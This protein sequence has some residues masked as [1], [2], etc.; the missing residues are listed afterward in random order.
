[1]AAYKNSHFTDLAPKAKRYEEPDNDVPGLR[2][3]VH[4]SGAKSWVL[5]YWFGSKKY[6]L[7]IGGFPGVDVAA[8]R[9]VAEEA[10]AKVKLGRNPAQEKI[11]ARQTADSEAA[12]AFD[13]VFALYERKH[14]NRK[15]K[16][17]TAAEA[18]RLFKATI[19]P[20]L[21]KKKLPEITSEDV[22]ELLD[23]LIDAGSPVTANRVLAA[24]RHFFK[25]A[26]ARKFVAASPVDGLERPTKETPRDRRLTDQEIRWLWLACERAK[27]HVLKKDALNSPT[28]AIPQLLLLTGT[29][30]N[31]VCA[32]SDAEVKR[33]SA[34][35]TIPAART[36]NG[37]AHE[38]HLSKVALGILDD[39]PR[40]KNPAKFVFCT[41]GR[42]SISGFSRLKSRIDRLM[43]EIARKEDPQAVI[44]AWRVHD[45]RRTTAS[46]MAAL[47]VTLPVIE[48]CLNHVSGSF[49][50]IVGVY[51]QHEFTA[52]RK[53]A[54]ELWTN[55]VKGIVERGGGNV[56]PLAARRAR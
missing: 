49:G 19:R 41:N 42:T 8:A 35:W 12:A 4:P 9:D 5:R 38:V 46:G 26:V 15:L 2:M 43:L 44:P 55:H 30:R 16:A 18:K 23:D 32:M 6:A 56:I 22:I 51:Q 36:K 40:V 53:A 45:L 11:A 28:G 33:D 37:R 29:R 25:F 7:T 52:E 48:R 50:G 54:F 17:S 21:S 13:K 34:V 24:L 10:R 27:K 1:M 20:A 14:I 47:G 39:V 31:E 3:A